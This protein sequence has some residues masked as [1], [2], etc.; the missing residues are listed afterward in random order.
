MKVYIGSDHGGFEMKEQLKPYIESL[1]FQVVD[2]GAYSRDPVD[3]PDITFL[4]AEK[5]SHD[6]GALGIM[7]DGAGIGSAV[8]ANKVPG[9][10]AAPCYDTY[11]A[12]NS[13][14]HNDVNMLT[15]GGRVTGAGMAEEIV[16]VWLTTKFLGGRH[17]RRVDKI[18]SVEQRF[19]KDPS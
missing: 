8:T 1:G 18:M 19:L 13:R 6:Q 17:S 2:F 14:E 4:V 12:R 3:Y 9:V 7:I 11:C 10:R 16:K 5:V 15:L